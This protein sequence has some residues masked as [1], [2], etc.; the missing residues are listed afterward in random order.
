MEVQGLALGEHIKAFRKAKNFTQ[1][2]L[3]EKI[4]KSLRML[5]KYV[6]GEVV[7]SIRVLNS[8]AVAL[9]I[10]IVEFLK[11]PTLQDIQSRELIV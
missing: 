9:D 7:P 4:G 11:N 2:N 3:S 5:Q 6:N 10:S 8:I 1:K